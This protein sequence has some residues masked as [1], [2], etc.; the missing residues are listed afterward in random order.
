MKLSIS[1][2]AKLLG[3]SVRTLHYYDEIGLLKPSELSEAGYRFYDAAALK[4]LQQIVFFR[5]L[6]FPLSEIA[7]LLSRPDY[8]PVPALARRRELLVLQRQHIDTLLALVDDTIGGNEIM[9]KQN[10]TTAADIEAAKKQYA[11]EAAERWGKTEA[12]RESE[13]RHAAYTD[14][15][16]A[17]IAEDANAIFAAFAAHMDQAPGAPEVQAL[18]KRWQD[19]ITKYHY[20]CTKEILAGLGQMYVGD[21]RFTETLDRFGDGNAR[22]MSEAIAAYCAQ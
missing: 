22:F 4:K 21:A 11:A 16:E 12:Y 14:T 2:T 1:E 6:E 13:K 7:A 8:D 17:A 20:T 10:K 3:V 19:H 18:V 15:Q 9:S 5:E